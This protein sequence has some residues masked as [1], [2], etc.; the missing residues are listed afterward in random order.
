MAFDWLDRQ[1]MLHGDVLP[2]ELLSQG[3]QLEGRR[4]P[5]VSA[6]GIFKPAVCPEIPLT[7]TTSP[8]SPYG[9]SFADDHRLEYRYRGTDPFHR[10]NVG[11]REAKRRRTPLIYLFG[12]VPGRYLPIWPVFVVGDDP[13]GLRFTVMADDQQSIAD[14]LVA[15]ADLEAGRAQ[16]SPRRQYITA[17][18]QVRLHQRGF[19][20]RVLKAYREQCSLCRLKHRELLDASHIIPDRDERGE[21]RVSNGLSLC[22]IHHTAFD[23]HFLGINPDGV[24]HIRRDLL[25]ETDGPMLQ[26]GLKDMHGL[27]LTVPS[28]CVDRPDREGLA[29]RFEQF[30]EVQG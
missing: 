16:D 28:R 14:T 3:F 2:R 10:D 22:K 1:T 30:M 13:G 7:I 4:V 20:E 25:E 21:P 9:D 27:K 24:I 12:L 6:Q 8:N 17:A 23:R 15:G 18:V 19:R 26:H 5:F 11:L 29:M